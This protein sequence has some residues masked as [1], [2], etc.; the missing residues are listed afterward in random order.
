MINK[1]TPRGRVAASIAGKRLY[2]LAHKE[3]G[4][5]PADRKIFPNLTV[6][7]NLEIARMLGTSVLNY[8]HWTIRE[9]FEFFPMLIKL[10]NR[11][12]NQLR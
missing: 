5:K 12:G 4:Y 3:M 6:R 8:E 1:I 11:C 10:E 9:V 2:Q 7:Q